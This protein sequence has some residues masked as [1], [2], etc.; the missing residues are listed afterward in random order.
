M[1]TLFAHLVEKH[2][3]HILYNI[4]DNDLISIWAFDSFNL[5]VWDRFENEY[6]KLPQHIYFILFLSSDD[7]C[8]IE[9]KLKKK[10]HKFTDTKV[11]E[12]RLEQMCVRLLKMTYNIRTYRLTF[13]SF[14]SIQSCSTRARTIQFR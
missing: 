9:I 7:I 4:A 8:F 3:N 6:I 13:N 11:Q 14:N 1:K 12:N 2:F 5:I 10:Q